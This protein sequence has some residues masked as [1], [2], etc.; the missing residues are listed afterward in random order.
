MRVVKSLLAFA[1]VIIVSGITTVTH[2][3][4]S[5]IEEA[6]TAVEGQLVDSWQDENYPSVVDFRSPNLVNPSLFELVNQCESLIDTAGLPQNMKDLLGEPALF[7]VSQSEEGIKHRV[8]AK[9]DLSRSETEYLY[10]LQSTRELV[11][12]L[13]YDYY[14]IFANEQI[15]ATNAQVAQAITAI[16]QD[17]AKPSIS[18]LLELSILESLSV[19]IFMAIR[20]LA[21]ILMKEQLRTASERLEAAAIAASEEQNSL[22]QLSVADNHLSKRTV[23]SSCIDN[24]D[25]PRFTAIQLT[26]RDKE[27]SVVHIIPSQ[28]TG[29]EVYLGYNTGDK[30]TFATINKLSQL[31]IN[32][33]NPTLEQAFKFIS[34]WI[35]YMPDYDLSVIE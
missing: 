4:N 24:H 16:L 1:V 9:Y 13:F 34:V 26:D 31:M 17:S 21:I 19:S 28:T 20:N 3:E 11:Y 18:N 23:W 29:V 14:M 5:Q 6:I 10:I 25:V 7:T 32:G 8:L 27:F 35:D 22:K 15:K 30:P 33:H 12:L 2:A